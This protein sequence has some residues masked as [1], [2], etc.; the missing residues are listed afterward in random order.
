MNGILIGITLQPTK[1]KILRCPHTSE[2]L[3]VDKCDKIIKEVM[4]PS[5][6]QKEYFDG[7]KKGLL[8]I[9]NLLD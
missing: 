2:K 8:E 3:P 1:I 5:F 9:L 4:L 7:T 6:A